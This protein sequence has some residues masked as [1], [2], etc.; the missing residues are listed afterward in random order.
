MDGSSE[1]LLPFV[2]VVRCLEGESDGDV[3]FLGV[4]PISPFDEVDGD[5]V[6]IQI[7]DLLEVVFLYAYLQG[8]PGTLLDLFES[9]K[10]VYSLRKDGYTTIND[11]HLL[12]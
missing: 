7:N 6:V 10:P 4:F 5:E 9:Q 12:D 2:L 1:F 3:V 11:T 8:S